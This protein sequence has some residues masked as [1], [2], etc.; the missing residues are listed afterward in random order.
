MARALESLFIHKDIKK[1]MI[2][3]IVVTLVK[4]SKKSNQNACLIEKR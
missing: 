1:Y 2:E 3:S 4:Y